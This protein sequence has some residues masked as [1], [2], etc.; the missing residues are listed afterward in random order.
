MH[1]QD[2]PG[3]PGRCLSNSIRVIEI[4]SQ[5]WFVAA[6]V[7]RMLTFSRLT[8]CFAYWDRTRGKQPLT[9]RGVSSTLYKLI[10]R[11]DKPEARAFQDWVTRTVLSAIRKDGGYILGEEKVSTGEM[12]EKCVCL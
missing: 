3:A 4:G 6:D 9:R 8:T 5:P 1:R 7:C 10:M 11:S 12:D 2:P